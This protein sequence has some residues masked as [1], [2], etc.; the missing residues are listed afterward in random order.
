MRREQDY[1]SRVGIYAS[2]FSDGTIWAL[3][4]HRRV[5]VDLARS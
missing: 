3:H 1:V 4:A 2:E 5:N